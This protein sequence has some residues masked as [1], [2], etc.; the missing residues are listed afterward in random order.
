MICA[1]HARLLAI[2]AATFLS[3]SAV[4]Q[5]ATSTSVQNKQTTLVTVRWGARTGVSRYRLQVAQDGNFTDIV[6]DKVV[7][8]HEYSVRDLEP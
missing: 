2:L 7:Y 4:A 1:T 3:A 5:P 8:G 6:F